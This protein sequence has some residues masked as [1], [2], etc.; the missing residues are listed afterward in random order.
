MASLTASKMNKVPPTTLRCLEAKTE[1]STDVMSC[2]KLGRRPTKPDDLER[3]LVN[4]GLAMEAKLFGSERQDVMSLS[5]QLAVEN[6]IAPM[7]LE[8]IEVPV[9]IG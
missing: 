4:Y 5:H 3:Q 6:N 9:K 7:F 8:K 1:L 2:A